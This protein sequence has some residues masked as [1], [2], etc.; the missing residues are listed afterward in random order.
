MPPKKRTN[1]STMYKV[2][3]YLNNSVKSMNSS[4]IFAGVMIILM[5]VASK[6]VNFRLSKTM[7]SYLKHTFSRDILVFAAAWMGTRD[8]YTALIITILFMICVNYLFN[9]NSR[10][11][12]LSEQFT[13]YHA[14]LVKQDVSEDDVKKAREVLS[15]YEEKMREKE[16]KNA[17][18][19]GTL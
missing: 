8:I 15:L 14:E 10:F 2:F 6:F 11:C 9:E 18:P 17:K 7:E 19:D 13:T 12:C 5:N 4:K 3:S 1:E 16:D